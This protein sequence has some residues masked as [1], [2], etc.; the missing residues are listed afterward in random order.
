MPRKKHPQ[1]NM[2]VWREYRRTRG[3]KLR[4]AIVE[5]YLY[6]VKQIR[7]LMSQKLP[8]RVEWQDLESEGA[9]GLIAA[10]EHYD[11]DRGF[12]FPTYASFRIRGAMLDWLRQ[13][14]WTPRPIRERLKRIHAASAESSP[15]YG[16]EYGRMAP[17]EIIAERLGVSVGLIWRWLEDGKG[18]KIQIPMSLLTPTDERCA[19]GLADPSSPQPLDQVSSAAIRGLLRRLVELL[20]DIRDQQI[21]RM[22]L[23]GWTMKEIAAVLGTSESRISQLVNKHILPQ[24]RRLMKGAG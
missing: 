9:I 5:H 11:L 4:N 3:V 22:R 12:Q 15:E 14:D 10:V 7:G 13:Q 2:S 23:Q 16:P 17:L 18:E 6:L 1:V 20:P 8:K 21:A 24:M 19:F